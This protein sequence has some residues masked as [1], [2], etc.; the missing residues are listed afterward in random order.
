MAFSD[1]RIRAP[2]NWRGFD[3]AHMNNLGML[4]IDSP[5]TK[6]FKICKI[7]TDTLHAYCENGFKNIFNLE[8]KIRVY[9]TTGLKK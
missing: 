7:V 8:K 1:P 4:L 2:K 3:R 5:I 6:K 9:I